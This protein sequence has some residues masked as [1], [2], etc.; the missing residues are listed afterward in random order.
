MENDNY[1]NLEEAAE[2]LGVTA[3]TLRNW[4]KKSEL[5]FPAYKA[6]HQWKLKRSEIDEWLNSGKGELAK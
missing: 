3:N 6:G 1:I 2:Y 5:E 4:I